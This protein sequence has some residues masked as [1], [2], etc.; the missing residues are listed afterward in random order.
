M[1]RKTKRIV[2]LTDESTI[3]HDTDSFTVDPG[4]KGTCLFH[5]LMQNP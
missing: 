5:M 1:P 4:A 3:A 2:D